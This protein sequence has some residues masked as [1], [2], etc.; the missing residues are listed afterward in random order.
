MVE[1]SARTEPGLVL[2]TMSLHT[3]AQSLVSLAAEPGHEGGHASLSPFVTG[4]GALFVLLLLLWV[5]TR[6]NRDR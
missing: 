1:V 5:T 4:G 2:L 6:F 3:T